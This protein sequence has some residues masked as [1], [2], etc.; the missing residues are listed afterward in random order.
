MDYLYT[1]N[2]LNSHP[3]TSNL[4]HQERLDSLKI[5]KRQCVI[6]ITILHRIFYD[7]EQT[8]TIMGIHINFGLMACLIL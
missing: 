4:H 8:R 3:T 7:K 2:T 1:V 6:F 5:W